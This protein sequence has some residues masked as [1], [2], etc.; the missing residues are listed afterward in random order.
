[1]GKS[2]KQ[3][4]SH[5]LRKFSKACE[6]PKSHFAG[7]AKNSQTQSYLAK[8]CEK[9]KRVCKPSSQ[10]EKSILQACA[11]SKSPCEHKRSLKSLFKDL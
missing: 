8:T 7:H 11:N 3:S 1:M 2:E 5:T 9:L 6:N 4:N 10:P